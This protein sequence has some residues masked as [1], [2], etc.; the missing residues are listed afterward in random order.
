MITY[1]NII[2]I[3]NKNI[4]KFNF[5]FIISYLAWLFYLS[6]IYY[7]SGYIKGGNFKNGFKLGGDSVRYIEAANNILQLKLPEGKSL[8]YLSYDIFVAL[9][10]LVRNNLF[11][12]V[13]IQ[14]I[15]T[16]FAAFCL[17]KITS[18]M[19]NKITG[20][21]CF[22]LFLFFPDIQM[23]NFYILTESLIISIP[24]ISIFL[25]INYNNYKYFLGY[26]L[27]IFACFIRPHAIILFPVL[28]I[29]IYFDLK[30]LNNKF[31]L[32]TFYS[33]LI[34][35]IPILLMIINYLINREGILVTLFKGEL[36]KHYDGLKIKSPPNVNLENDSETIFDLVYVLFS[37][38]LFFLKVFF[39]K[40]FW[41][42]ARVRPYYSEIHNLF[43][44]VYTIPIYITFII[45][46]FTK[47]EKNNLKIAMLIYMFLVT[48]AVCITT[49]DWSGRFILPIIP[50]I[51]IFSSA[52]TFF[53]FN[54]IYKFYIFRLK[55]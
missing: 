46:V 9:I 22:L 37:Y 51:L 20:S 2:V 52:G 4:S 7:L 34:I 54:K 8:S 19:F 27:L 32:N 25:I 50:M 18:I 42:Y 3:M 6:L 44:I 49:L 29:L 41:F 12:V 36:I 5:F 55:T 21:I 40:L 16:G 35:F 53:L 24:I 26:I 38:P 31:I 15:L 30:K 14:I 48:F 28:I 47:N 13:I 39:T 11:D 33:I 23:R 1:L 43:I 10:L 17:F 45:G